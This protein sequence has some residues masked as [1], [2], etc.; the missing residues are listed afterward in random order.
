M[1]RMTSNIPSLAAGGPSLAI[2]FPKIDM[3]HVQRGFHVVSL[4]EYKM[5][6]SE[7]I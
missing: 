4:K 3:E 2:V 7:Y 5:I 6:L 1:R